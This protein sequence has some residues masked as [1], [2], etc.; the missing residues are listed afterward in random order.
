MKK[1]HTIAL[2]LS[3]AI[4]AASTGL[5][6]YAVSKHIPKKSDPVQYIK[7]EYSSPTPP[8][9]SLSM[10]YELVEIGGQMTFIMYPEGFPNIEEYKLV[11]FSHGSNTSVTN[12]FDNPNVRDMLLYGEKFASQGYI[13]TASNMHGANWG[14]FEA[15]RDMLNVSLYLSSPE[16]NYETVEIY[17]IGYSM[18]ALAIMSS[19]TMPREE[20]NATKIALLAPTTRLYEWD[21]ER[22][23]DLGDTQIK[24]WHG[25]N[26]VNIPWNLSN[27]F[28]NK[29]EL[30]DYDIE[31]ETVE[32]AAHFDLDIEMIDDIIE[33]FNE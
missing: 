30:Y 25:D 29:A 1:A 7:P 27:S 26:D 3:I 21:R 23:E 19:A 33:Y 24:I 28:V 15:H 2:L 8:S 4:A 6:L 18:G 11:H 32:G 22:F 10:H 16:H 20:L 13:F 9:Q 31:F 5:T 14:S 17:G 12:S